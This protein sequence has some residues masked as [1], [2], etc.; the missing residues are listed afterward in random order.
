M[1]GVRCTRASQETDKNHETGGGC[2]GWTGV[3]KMKKIN[4]FVDFYVS[5]L[6]VAVGGKGREA[7]HGRTCESACVSP[8]MCVCL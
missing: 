3:G 6:V 7:Q 8:S 2:K 5:L 1:E 4:V